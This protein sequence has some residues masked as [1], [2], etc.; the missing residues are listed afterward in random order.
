MTKC[1]E[2]GGEGWISLPKPE[3]T[4]EELAKLSKE[5]RFNRLYLGG[6]W[7]HRRCPNGCPD[8]RE[9]KGDGR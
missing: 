6:E 9:R 5:Q 2:C 8:P 7:E 1:K 4:E 3:P